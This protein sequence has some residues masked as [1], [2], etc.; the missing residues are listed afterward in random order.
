MSDHTLKRLTKK[1]FSP[2]GSTNRLKTTDS[3]GRLGRKHGRCESVF[4]SG[5]VNQFSYR[6]K[7]F[8]IMNEYNKTKNSN[9]KNKLPGLTEKINYLVYFPKERL[10]WKMIQH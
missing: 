6:E 4:I 5:D 10:I 8:K 2:K 9:R 3:E 1:F 7:K